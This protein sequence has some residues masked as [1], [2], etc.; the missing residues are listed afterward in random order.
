M[1]TG[2]GCDYL[3][4]SL[5]ISELAPHR[6]RT[7]DQQLQVVTTLKHLIDQAQTLLEGSAMQGHAIH[8][9]FHHPT[10]LEWTES[11][12]KQVRWDFGKVLN[13]TFAQRLF[14]NL[15]VGVS[16]RRVMHI[17]LFDLQLKIFKCEVHGGVVARTS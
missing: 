15:P 6:H 13:P 14:P 2:V 11:S 16:E 5:H 9:A 7:F 17:T 1:W 4:P 3:P 12:E 10:P 8:P